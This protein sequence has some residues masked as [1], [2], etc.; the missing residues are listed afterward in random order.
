MLGPLEDVSFGK[1][2]GVHR[3][4]KYCC[5]RES[6]MGCP[7]MNFMVKLPF[8]GMVWGFAAFRKELPTARLGQP[9]PDSIS[10]DGFLKS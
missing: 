7:G 8:Y 9:I 10:A 4:I 3:Q 5:S 6:F 1:F 2:N